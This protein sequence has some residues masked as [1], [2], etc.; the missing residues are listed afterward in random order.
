M[1]AQSLLEKLQLKDEKNLLIQGLP[2]SV[3]KQFSKL[4]FAK[5][6]TPL[7]KSRGV[8]FALVFAVNIDQLN[9][10]MREVLPALQEDAKLW[11]AYPKSSSKIATNLNRDYTWDILTNAGF[12][13]VR[14]V[15]LDHVWSAFRFKKEASVKHVPRAVPAEKS[16]SSGVNFVTRTITP[17][18][19]FENALL[20]DKVARKFFEK[21]SYTNKK[22]YVTWITGAKKEET[23]ASRIEAS[24]EKL[25]E[26]KKNPS[27]K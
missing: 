7:L 9:N 11:I 19:D 26:G 2:S 15:A 22:E 12:A 4:F 1:S 16:M 24:M 13:G 27:E 20:E 21:L 23:R 17:P 3:E 10:I 5:N 14:L 6:L 25:K 8:D 18:R